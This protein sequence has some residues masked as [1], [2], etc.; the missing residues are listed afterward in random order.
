MNKVLYWVPRILG[1]LSVLFMM[2]FGFD[3]F[4]GDE[5]FLKQ[6]LGFFMHTLPSWTLLVVLII[7][8]KYELAGGIV[9]I[10]AS[11]A[12]G[13][14]FR[15]FTTNLASLPVILPFLLTGLLFVLHDVMVK[16]GKQ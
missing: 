8:W 3:V 5:P 7:A 4:A 1:I 9:F 15:S 12:L 6:L 11:L 13:I 16:K 10:L 2:M 14:F